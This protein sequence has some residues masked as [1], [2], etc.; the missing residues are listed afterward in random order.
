VP[1]LDVD[2]LYLF[3]LLCDRPRTLR[4][5]LTHFGSAE[6][7]FSAPGDEIFGLHRLDIAALRKA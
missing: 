3:R 6:A 5:L 2:L 7:V 1:T 4:H